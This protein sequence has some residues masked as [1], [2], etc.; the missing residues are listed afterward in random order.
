MHAR[1]QVQQVAK[2][3]HFQGQK[4]E[5]LSMSFKGTM[6]LAQQARRR[7]P[8]NPRRRLVSFP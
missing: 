7:P 6:D 8:S 4:T 2:E 1:S 3:T 5:L